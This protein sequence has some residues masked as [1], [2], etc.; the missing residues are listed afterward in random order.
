MRILMLGWEFPPFISGGL[1]TACHGLTRAL[2]RLQAEI[3]FVLP[4]AL[5]SAGPA[6]TDRL[7]SALSGERPMHSRLWPRSAGFERVTFA[8]ASSALPSP[9]PPAALTG[10]STVIP[11]ADVC[12]QPPVARPL[13]TRVARPPLLVVGAGLDG[14]Y[15]GDLLSKI[16]RYVE[17]CVELSRGQQF[18]LIH[19]HDWVTFPA[20]KAI[21]DLSGRPLVV[22]IHATEFDRSGERIHQAI[23]D[24]ERFG[25]HAAAK[26]IAVSGR[27]KDTVVRRYGVAPAKVEVIHNGI[28]RDGA[29]GAPLAERADAKDKVALFLG[30]IT[31]QKG[32]EFFVRAAARVA[33]KLDRVRFVMAGSGDLAP[34]MRALVSA[35]GLEDRFEFP[36]FLQG[37]EVERAY[38]MAD[39]YVMPSVSEPF[40]ITA[41]EAVRC[42][43]PVI[44]SKNSG[45]AEV[46]RE[47]ALKVDFWDVELMADMMLA[48][49]RHPQ[50]GRALCRRAAAEIRAMTW[51][52]AAQKCL[53]VYQETITAQMLRRWPEAA[54]GARVARS[55]SAA[56]PH[57]GAAA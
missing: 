50:L 13:A 34:A 47:G 52:A 28:D 25:M 21:A 38:R 4:K 46:L 8:A 15:D 39:V 55:G 45:V 31:M 2:S 33:R 16:R 24:I 32:P 53:R 26:V 40:G 17:R 35:I 27:T 3:L 12:K 7:D 18:D 36:G 1:G 49:L 22:H 10:R 37:A 19:A 41:L 9:Y 29:D 5:G 6:A 20:A 30:R 11:A 56:Q 44:L 48:L 23:Y 43:V 54:L 42:G 14:G 57:S 51:R